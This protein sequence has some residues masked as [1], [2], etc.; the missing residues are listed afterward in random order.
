MFV[1]TRCK[2]LEAH[3]RLTTIDADSFPHVG[4]LIA[5]AA[6]VSTLAGLSTLAFVIHQAS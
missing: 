6:A 4:R 3:Q 1:V 5:S 2:Y